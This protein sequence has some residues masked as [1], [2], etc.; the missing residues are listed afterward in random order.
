MVSRWFL[1]GYSVW[2]LGYFYVAVFGVLLHYM[3][4]RLFWVIFRN[5]QIEVSLLY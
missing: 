3:V 2:L 4:A 5:I 1:E